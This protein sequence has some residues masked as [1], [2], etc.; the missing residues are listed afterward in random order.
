M[1][2]I[3]ILCSFLLSDSLLNTALYNRWKCYSMDGITI[4]LPITK[5]FLYNLCIKGILLAFTYDIARDKQKK[6]IK[7]IFK[8]LPTYKTNLKNVWASHYMQPQELNYI[9]FIMTVYVPKRIVL[10]LSSD[11]KQLC[12]L[13][14][15]LIYKN[16]ICLNKKCDAYN[17]EVYKYIS[18]DIILLQ[19][20]DLTFKEMYVACKRCQACKLCRKFKNKKCFRHK[21]CTHKDSKFQYRALNKI[22]NNNNV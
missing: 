8:V 7:V 16:D 12:K 14:N 19:Y 2:P 18:N 5:K 15:S 3:T 21:I 22:V 17:F 10:D 4:D 9:D 1:F 11:E 20:D 6:N 13:C